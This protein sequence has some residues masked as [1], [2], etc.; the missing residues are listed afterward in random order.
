WFANDIDFNGFPTVLYGAINGTNGAISTGLAY[1]G[2]SSYDFNP[3]IGVSDQGSNAFAVW[4]NWAYT[5]PSA[6]V[7]VSAA[8]NGVAP[9]GGVPNLAGTDL[10]L[11][12]GTSTTSIGTFGA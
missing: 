2:N 9:G 10:T 5:N 8:V 7:P 3:S 1:H 12:T 6:G 4:L 11:V